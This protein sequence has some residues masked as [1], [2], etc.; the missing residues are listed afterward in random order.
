MGRKPLSLVQML[1]PLIGLVVVSLGVGQ[2]AA[3][4]LLCGAA[5]TDGSAPVRAEL[6]PPAD[7]SV[8]TLGRS[9]IGE[10]RWELAFTWS[11]DCSLDT[12]NVR[13]HISTLQGSDANLAVGVVVVDLDINSDARRI[14]ATLTMPRTL[15]KVPAG[16]FDG[17]VELTGTGVVGV[18][19]APFTIRHQ[20]PMTIHNMSGPEQV[21]WI[22]AGASV[23]AFLAV[24][25]SRERKTR[26]ASLLVSPLALAV[27]VTLYP[28]ASKLRGSDVPSLWWPIWL[29][30]FG[31]VGGFVVA[32]L[33]Q[34][35]GADVTSLN[36]R[37]GAAMTLS[38]GAGIAVW[39]SQYLNTPDWALT[40]ESALSLIGVVGGATVTSALLLLAPA[41]PATPA[42][43]SA[44][45]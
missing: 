11:A 44:A 35:S 27:L 22:L 32:V 4:T 1:V 39:R 17:V 6:A 37:F 31:L 42:P 7:P 3:A 13:A 24:I 29:G 9:T 20:E 8:I 26:W 18:A 19:S 14:V 5:T 25:V 23:A 38:F 40:M 21:I 16:K 2:S 45:G 36:L 30:G 10:R 41:T 12:T 43:P 15:S 28:L 34:Q 33:K